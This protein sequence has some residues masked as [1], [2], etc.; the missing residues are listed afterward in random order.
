MVGGFFHGFNFS[1]FFQ[2]FQF[3]IFSIFFF[4]LNF[5]VLFFVNLVFKLYFLWESF[6]YCILFFISNTFFHRE[7]HRLNHAPIQIVRRTSSEIREWAR[8]TAAADAAHVINII[9]LGYQENEQMWLSNKMGISRKVEALRTVTAC[10]CERCVRAIFISAWPV[11]TAPRQ[12]SDRFV[13][14][15]LQRAAT[16]GRKQ[17]WIN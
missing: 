4:S 10:L 5:F 2:F 15:R 8:W 11:N 7:K 6:N 9:T 14:V 17:L 3:S 1:I 13:C 16:V 12:V